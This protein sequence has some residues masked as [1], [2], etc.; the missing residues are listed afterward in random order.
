MIRTSGIAALVSFFFLVTQCTEAPKKPAPPQPLIR[1]K[2][3]VVTS[4]DTTGILR[5]ERYPNGKLRTRGRL[6]NGMRQGLWESFYDTGVK[7]SDT[8]YRKGKRH[9]ATASYF[10]DGKLRYEGFYKNDSP[11]GVWNFYN[12]DGSFNK[13]VDYNK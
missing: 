12:P 11:A 7:W 4:A 5:E 10:E 3:E 2:G 9:G 13:S 8:H 6:Q 1:K